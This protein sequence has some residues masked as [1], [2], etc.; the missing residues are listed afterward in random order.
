MEIIM[1][2]DPAPFAVT[3]VAATSM[4]WKPTMLKC[5]APFAVTLST[6]ADQMDEPLASA[7]AGIKSGVH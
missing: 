2:R 3:I 1:L 4:M 7:A 6:A 5:P